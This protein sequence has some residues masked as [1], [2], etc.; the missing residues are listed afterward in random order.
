MRLVHEGRRLRRALTPLLACEIPA[1]IT[2]LCCKSDAPILKHSCKSRSSL[3][4]FDVYYF[5][6]AGFC[7]IELIVVVAV[8]YRVVASCDCSC[9]MRCPACTPRLNTRVFPTVRNVFR[10]RARHAHL[11]VRA[12]AE[13]DE[14]A[15]KT[16]DAWFK[17]MK[18]EFDPVSSAPPATA[19]LDFEKPL[20]ELDRRIREVCGCSFSITCTSCMYC[21]VELH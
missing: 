11:V 3:V 2:I 17:H 15:H 19:V 10:L 20:V 8:Y 13:S 16:G 14:P 12:E 1:R 21:I 6:S 9:N 18:S 4:S 5:F 7:S